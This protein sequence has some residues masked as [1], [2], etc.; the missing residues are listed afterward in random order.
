M[1]T[2]RPPSRSGSTDFE[3]VD[4]AVAGLDQPGAELLALDV[5]QR[6]GGGDMGGD[7]AAPLG[8]QRAKAATISRRL[9][10]RRLAAMTPTKSRTGLEKPSCSSTASA[11]L[12]AWFTSI[13][14]DSSRRRKSA[15]ASDQATERLHV[16]HHGVERVLL[17]G[18]RIECRGVAVGQAA[19]GCDR[20]SANDHVPFPVPGRARR[21]R[22]WET[23]PPTGGRRLAWGP[24]GS[25]RGDRALRHSQGSADQS[26]ATTDRVAINRRAG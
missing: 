5:R 15:L 2:T 7:D 8:H 14:G 23:G 26:I 1:R 20:R 11:A 16:R 9:R 13:S 21:G 12:V 24:A 4:V 19:A 22:G 17:I 6:M 10:S 25:N 18:V 3:D